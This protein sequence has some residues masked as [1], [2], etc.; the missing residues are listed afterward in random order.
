MPFWK[1]KPVAPASVFGPGAP[2]KYWPTTGAGWR[3]RDRPGIYRIVARDGTIEYIGKTIH[4]YPRM[5]KHKSKGRFSEGQ[6][7]EYQVAPR[8]VSHRAL[9]W[10]EKKK[11]KKHKPT[12]NKSSGG[13]GRPPKKKKKRRWKLFG[14]HK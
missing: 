7:F 14:G 2:R 12:K 1:S 8:G 6:S 5:L 4:L 9:V 13:E 11:I 10:E 3:P